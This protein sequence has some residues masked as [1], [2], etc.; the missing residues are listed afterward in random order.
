MQNPKLD[1][2]I[3]AI[4]QVVAEAVRD[5]IKQLVGQFLDTAATT[6]ALQPRVE[7]AR[8]LVQNIMTTSANGRLVVQAYTQAVKER[9]DC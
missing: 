4:K 3:D 8:L 1:M 6:E 7:S 9:E 5:D 2:E